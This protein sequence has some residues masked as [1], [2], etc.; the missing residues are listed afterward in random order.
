MVTSDLVS[1]PAVPAVGLGEL[2]FRVDVSPLLGSGHLVRCQ[3]LADA[4]QALGGAARFL[5]AQALAPAAAEALKDAGHAW[6]VLVSDEP[7]AAAASQ[8][9]PD[10]RQQADAMRC[11]AVLDGRKPAWLVVDHYG[12]GAP[13]QVAMAPAGARVLALDDLANRPHQAHLLLD[14]NF[15]ADPA[16]RYAPWVSPAIRL[17]LGP[18]FAL[19][20]PGFARAPDLPPRTHGPGRSLLVCFGGGAPGRIVESVV[21]AAALRPDWSLTVIA[22]AAQHAALKA[23]VAPGQALRLLEFSDDMPRLMLEADLAIGAGGGTLWERFCLGLP[24]LVF[25]LADNQ[26]PGL[27]SLLAVGLVGGHAD[28][29]LLEDGEVR[30]LVLAALDDPVALQLMADRAAHLVDGHGARRVAVA[31]A[32]PLGA[33]HLR[34]AAAADAEP[35]WH[36]RNAPSTRAVSTDSAEL[37]LATHLAWWQASLSSADRRLWMAV[38]GQ[39]AVG[40][41]RLDIAGPDATVSIYCD[42]ALTGMGLGPRMLADLVRRVRDELKGVQR[43]LA[44]IRPDNLASR[45]AFASVGFIEAGPQWVLDLGA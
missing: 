24:G 7:A 16:S 14:Q 21:G 34:P 31:L 23:L 28:V 20:R 32:L 15:H 17:L 38:V 39:A 3:A 42:P 45:R 11:L 44:I 1:A 29:R 10:A 2:V 5:L 35:A 13:W 26:V 37:Q 41:L 30:C 27:S 8:A 6:Q 18:R 43:L 22:P 9:W 40:V 19:L 4:W 25:G 36:W 12:L 33:L